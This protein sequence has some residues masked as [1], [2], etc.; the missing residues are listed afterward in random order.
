MS[1]ELKNKKELVESLRSCN[2]RDDVN[3]LF[4]TYEVD[5]LKQRVKL[6]KQA[7]G[8]INE[9]FAGGDFESDEERYEYE[10]I[11]FEDGAWRLFG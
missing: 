10:L 8:V 5:D 4:D 9:Y 11:I 7:T 6:L 2:N 1:V 3:A